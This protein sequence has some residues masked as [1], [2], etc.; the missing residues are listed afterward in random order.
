MIK[1]FCNRLNLKISH[2]GYSDTWSPPKNDSD[3][4]EVKNSK[5]ASF[6]D[7]P[8]LKQEPPTPS[9]PV[10]TAPTVRP[11]VNPE[12]KKT[13]KSEPSKKI[14]L[15]AAANYKGDTTVVQ[16]AAPAPKSSDLLEDLFSL[17]PVPAASPTNPISS[18]GDNFADFSQFPPPQ[19][20]KPAHA[21][22]THFADFES[23]FTS[24]TMQPVQPTIQQVPSFSETFMSSNPFASLP[25][26]NPVAPVLNPVFSKQTDLL[27]EPA[28][29]F[30]PSSGT[31]VPDNLSAANNNVG[32]GT[33]KE[34]LANT[35]WGN[36]GLDIDLDNLLTRDTKTAAPSMN[37]LAADVG[38]VNV[39]Q[40]QQML[41]PRTL[42]LAFGGE[43]FLN[44]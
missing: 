40:S 24:E 38:R 26:T 12:V 18:L 6:S 44:R 31:L 8:T 35:T 11:I 13:K 28:N 33:K 3:E 43:L 19:S 16:T 20:E 1:F 27:N 23:A 21:A 29:M 7:L 36:L 22:S 4:D 32:A 30:Q 25:S 2:R 14:D 39:N 42:S 9:I 15:G 5:D 10:V 41:Q 34:Q 17:S 37:Q